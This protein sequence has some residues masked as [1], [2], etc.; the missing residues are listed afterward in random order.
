MLQ[1]AFARDHEGAH[2]AEEFFD[3]LSVIERAQLQK[4]FE[5]LCNDTHGEPRNPKKFGVLD[6]GLYE[7]KSFQIRMPFAYAKSERGLV[8]ITHG[9]RKKK[10]KTP[11]TE[12]TKAKKILKEDAEASKVYLITDQKK[13]K[14]P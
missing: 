2:P 14:R 3:G 7:F 5:I 4:L 1:I 11:P 9:F 10:D 13:R 6:D 8:L 12:I